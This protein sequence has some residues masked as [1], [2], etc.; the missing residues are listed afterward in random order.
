VVP[1]LIGIDICQTHTLHAAKKSELDRRRRSR[2]TRRDIP[3]SRKREMSDNL[4]D[5][6]SRLDT[7]EARFAQQEKVIVDLNEVITAQW[8]R[9]DALG[10]QILQLREEYQ[11][12]DLPRDRP[13]PPPPHY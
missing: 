2:D 6:A 8:K 13:E 12:L 3:G 5:P 7:L 10:R 4:W 1:T 9:I 11:T